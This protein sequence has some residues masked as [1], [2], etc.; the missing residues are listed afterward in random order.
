MSYTVTKV[1]RQP[2]YSMV[3]AVDFTCQ[4]SVT[5]YVHNEHG[6]PGIGRHEPTAPLVRGLTHIMVAQTHTDSPRQ[7]QAGSMGLNIQSLY[8]A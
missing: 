1:N 6:K 5:I 8:L 4:L 2:T 7:Q 3:A